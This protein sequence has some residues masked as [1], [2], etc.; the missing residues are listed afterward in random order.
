MVR[1]IEDLAVGGF[2][3]D[4]ESDHLCPQGAAANSWFA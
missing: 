4:L 2:G 3:S 1:S